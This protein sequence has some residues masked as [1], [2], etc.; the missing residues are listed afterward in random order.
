MKKILN[1]VLTTIMLIVTV[2][3][4]TVFADQSN[5]VTYSLAADGE[6]WVSKNFQVKEFRC[7][8]NKVGIYCDTI[9]IDGELVT[10]LQNIRDHFGK[11]VNIN[12]AYRCKERND[13]LTGAAPNSS[14]LYGKA[15][16]IYIEGVTQYELAEYAAIIGVPHVGRDSNYVHIGTQ[17]SKH[18][19]YGATR[20]VTTTHV[21]E[22]LK[23]SQP[24]G[25]P[26]QLPLPEA[27]K[28]FETIQENNYYLKNGNYYISTA[29]TLIASTSS[30]LE[31]AI[32]KDRD[33]Y[34]VLST[35]STGKNILN[36]SASTSSNGSWVILW[37]DTTNPS[38]RWY[39]E[40]C[41]DGYLIHPA[42]N[43]SL[44]LTRNTSTNKLYV[45][46]TTKESNQIWVLESTNKNVVSEC[47]HNWTSDYEAAHPHKVFNRC[48]T[49]GQTSYTG[50]TKKVDGC[51]E[52]YPPVKT[53]TYY[54]DINGSLDG[55]LSGSLGNCG[56]F[57]L[58][59]NGKKVCEDASDYYTQ[60]PTGTKFE[61]KDIKA[62]SGYKYIGETGGLFGTVGT[63]N[64][65]VCLNFETEKHTHSWKYDYEAHPH[66]QY[67]YCSCGEKEYTGNTEKVDN[68]EQCNPTTR[69]TLY[70]DAN[71]GNE[72]PSPK[73]VNSGDKVTVSSEKLS[74]SGYKFLGWSENPKSELA[75]YNGGERITITEDITLYAIWKPKN[76]STSQ[77][78]LTIGSTKATVFGQTAYNDVAPVLENARTML[79]AR[80]V[81]ENL[82]ASVSW[83]DE[84][85]T[86]IIEKDSIYIE[87]IIGSSYAY[88]NGEPVYLD[89][90][91]FLRNSRTYTPVRFIC[92]SLG[93]K[94]DWDDAKQ[95]VIITK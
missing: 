14:H 39:F 93:A 23:G 27:Y 74:R 2:A 11:P 31:F 35:S 85:Q 12:G 47:V 62:K 17:V 9:L 83:V 45:N 75:V 64:H 33:F 71:G 90:P 51:D 1:V 42:D 72:A 32:S 66:K 6:K 30:K 29:D 80:F 88:V 95:Q 76:N 28:S 25:S 38:Q 84:T 92:E 78:I 10:I 81:A 19:Y 46:T 16:D 40:K 94:V 55:V 22:D 24:Y 69:V 50:N 52:C 91:A 41:G 54:L 49:C 56:T 63:N 37:T 82:G 65:A 77:I 3:G 67:K 89:S 59:I 73:T 60:H 44:S 8:H 58:Y 53:Y 86:V 48:R 7:S 57:D 26:T 18:Y 43:I 15:A 34:K 4:I 20:E 13:S 87:I 5:V 79:P 70:Y 68:C 21:A 36:V 61:I